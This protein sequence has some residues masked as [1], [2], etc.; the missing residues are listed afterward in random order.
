MFNYICKV[1]NMLNKTSKTSWK[2][3][4]YLIQIFVGENKDMFSAIL[5][6]F[7][8]HFTREFFHAYWDYTIAGDS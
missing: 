1:G 6:H 2:C 8:D 7:V 5:P 3:K 4:Q